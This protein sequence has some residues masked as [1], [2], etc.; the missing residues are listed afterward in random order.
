MDVS[1]EESKLPLSFRIQHHRNII[2]PG[3]VFTLNEAAIQWP[4]S[5]LLHDNLFTGRGGTQGMNLSL[6]PAAAA[7]DII[8]LHP[9]GNS[10]ASVWRLGLIL[11]W[12][13]HPSTSSGTSLAERSKNKWCALHQH[14]AMEDTQKQHLHD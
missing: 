1:R 2:L 5:Q 11:R 7:R 9:K 4:L 8:I 12:S 10:R 13:L 14:G 6:C 3:C